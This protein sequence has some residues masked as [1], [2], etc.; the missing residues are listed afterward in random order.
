[1]KKRVICI[2]TEEIYEGAK[3]ASKKTG[4]SETKVRISLASG[5]TVDNLIFKWENPGKLYPP[6][7]GQDFLFPLPDDIPL[8]EDGRT[9]GGGGQW[10]KLESG[11]YVRIYP[12]QKLLCQQTQEEF[13]SI[14]EASDKLGVGETQIRISLASGVEV[15]GYTFERIGSGEVARKSYAYNYPKPRYHKKAYRSKRPK[16]HREIL[17]ETLPMRDYFKALRDEEFPIK[18]T[19]DHDYS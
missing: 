13:E 11:D 5:A 8:A 1:M 9:Y 14:A 12:G 15:S 17:R 16:T 10:R 4:V 18:E 19:D 6:P 7:P 3:D 2:Q